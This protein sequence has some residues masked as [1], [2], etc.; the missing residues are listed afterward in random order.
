MFLSRFLGCF[1]LL[2]VHQVA[3]AQSDSP[4]AASAADSTAKIF[5]GLVSQEPDLPMFYSVKKHARVFSSVDSDESVASLEF[6][7]PVFLLQGLG[8]WSRVRTESGVEGFV[9]SSA[10]SNVW[11]L[12]SKTDKTVFVYSGNDLQ[13]SLAADLAYNFFSDK[14]M[15]GDV[16]RPDHYRTP[17][18]DYF[19]VSKNPRSQFYKAFVLNYPNESDAQDGFDRGLISTAQLAAIQRA[20]RSFSIPPMTTDLGGWIEIHGNGTGTRTS[21]TQGCVA[22]TD[23]N[24]DRLWHI[25]RVGTPVRIKR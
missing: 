19:V 18:G 7:E 23:D 17:E 13:F 10:L 20:A 12:I 1:A 6:Q 15:R 3:I 11:I 14:Q 16:V 9:L 25:V 21:W 8:K 4:T 24:M 22:L 5:S 2:L